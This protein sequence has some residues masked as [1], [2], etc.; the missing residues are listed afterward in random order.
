MMIF[1]P[2]NNR[3]NNFEAPKS[4]RAQDTRHAQNN[5]QVEDHASGGFSAK[6]RQPTIM[7]YN[8]PG[9]EL[10]NNRYEEVKHHFNN[11]MVLSEE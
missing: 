10:D 9:D 8:L 1:D 4:E 3:G 7:P 2:H 5:F 11:V 6:K